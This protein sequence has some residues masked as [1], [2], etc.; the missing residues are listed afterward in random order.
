MFR[1]RLPVSISIRSRCPQ[2][3]ELI[4]RRANVSALIIVIVI[5]DI[6]VVVRTCV[7]SHIE[8][9]GNYG[10]PYIVGLSVLWGCHLRKQRCWWECRAKNA[11]K[12]QLLYFVNVDYYSIF[13][14][15]YGLLELSCSASNWCSRLALVISVGIG[16]SEQFLWM[17]ELTSRHQFSQTIPV[18]ETVGPRNLRYFVLASTFPRSI[19][20][21]MQ[22]NDRLCMVLNVIWH[23]SAL[24]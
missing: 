15:T 18:Q 7:H 14:V 21:R 22:R 17:P 1:N 8:R 3:A 5:E 20:K 4:T 23:Q 6:R 13:K 24:S 10:N 12:Q 9:K 2:S 11:H 16:H 19:R